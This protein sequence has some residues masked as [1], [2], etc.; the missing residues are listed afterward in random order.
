MRMTAGEGQIIN[1]CVINL[2]SDH[3]LNRPK[4]IRLLNVNLSYIVNHVNQ[5]IR[6]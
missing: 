5:V 6:C 3:L 4:N 2:L 1:C